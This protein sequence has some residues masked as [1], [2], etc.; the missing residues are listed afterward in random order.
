[1][2]L[3]R[4][5]RDAVQ[6]DAPCETEAPASEKSASALVPEAENGPAVA[7]V[8]PRLCATRTVSTEVLRTKAR[9]PAGALS[10]SKPPR[11]RAPLRWRAS[12]NCR[13]RDQSVSQRSGCADHVVIGEE[14]HVGG[15]GRIRGLDLLQRADQ[16]GGAPGARCR[17][18]CGGEWKVESERQFVSAG[19]AAGRAV[20]GRDHRR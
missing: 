18:D 13:Y 11:A 20:V 8:L 17:E 10:S 5:P 15:P 2:P 7:C 3:A 4:G 19:H 1:A 9:T 14:G 6:R 12:I 16:A